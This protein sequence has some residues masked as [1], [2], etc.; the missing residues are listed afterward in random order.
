MGVERRSMSDDPGGAATT[1]AKSALR[2][3]AQ[4]KTC[5]WNRWLEFHNL[6]TENQYQA[7]TFTDLCF[8]DRL[9]FAI[10]ASG[11]P[12]KIISWNTHG[13][14]VTLVHH[15]WMVFSAILVMVLR[16][17]C[18]ERR[19]PYTTI[20]GR[21]LVVSRLRIIVSAMNTVLTVS[22]E[23]S[24][25]YAEDHIV[26]RML[27]RTSTA[28]LV[29]TALGLR[30]PFK[31]NVWVQGL[32]TLVSI[33]WVVPVTSQCQ[34]NPALASAINK[35]GHVMEEV[36]IRISVLG[37]PLSRQPPSPGE[38]PCWLVGLFMHVLV[39]FL[40]PLLILYLSELKSRVQF[41]QS[42]EIV[43]D[44][45]LGNQELKVHSWCAVA[46][47]SFACVV[48]TQAFWFTVKGIAHKVPLCSGESQI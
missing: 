37:C 33:P 22:E 12:L 25:V 26:M 47:M 20:Q 2:E 32:A 27:T 9:T 24:Q 1:S 13:K 34:L 3:E 6:Q 21:R 35:V 41:L 19:G 36:L 4:I 42:R 16:H 29:F 46:W 23:P 39:G 15:G 8:A 5:P 43:R 45:S 7:S 28:P 18:K 48:G 11:A 31:T 44:G 10:V 40:V 17:W 30:L 38:N 14:L